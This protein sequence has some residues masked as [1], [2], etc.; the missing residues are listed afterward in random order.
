MGISMRSFRFSQ[1]PAEL[2]P[3]DVRE[4]LQAAGL[5]QAFEHRS[6]TEQYRD[7]TR[8]NAADGE[9]V[10]AQRIDRIIATLSRD[11]QYQDSRWKT[12]LGGNV[13]TPA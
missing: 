8:V 7:I 5:L 1:R 9:A 11:S 10:R 13:R 4:R 2:I 3:E 12:G 6:I